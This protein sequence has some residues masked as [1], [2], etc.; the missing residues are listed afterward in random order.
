MAG[1]LKSYALTS[2][3]PGQSRDHIQ[4]LLE[5]VGAKGF[6]WSSSVGYPGHEMLEAALEVEKRLIA[7]R[8][9]V[10][11]AD[12]REHKQ[13]MRALYWYLKAKVEAIQFGLV[14][15]EREFLPYLLVAG[16]ETVYEQMGGANIKLLEA[17]SESDG[18]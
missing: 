17:P 3:P 15:L 4:K 14:D 11:F 18:L 10:N 16:G 6:R 9:Q 8:L 12:Q 7:F 2:V 13:K 1:S 5:V